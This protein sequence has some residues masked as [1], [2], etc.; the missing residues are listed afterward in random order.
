MEISVLLVLVALIQTRTILSSLSRPI[1][2]LP[3]KAFQG[4]LLKQRP[5]VITYYLLA[6][7][8]CSD[9]HSWLE[10]CQEQQSALGRDHVKTFFLEANNILSLQ[11]V[12]DRNNLQLWSKLRWKFQLSLINKFI[13]KLVFHSELLD[14]INLK[15]LFEHAGFVSLDWKYLPVLAPGFLEFQSARSYLESWGCIGWRDVMCGVL[16]CLV[17]TSGQE[18]SVMLLAMYFHWLQRS[19]F[20]LWKF[21]LLFPGRSM[22]ALCAFSVLR[23]EF[24]PGFRFGVLLDWRHILF[25]QE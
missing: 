10:K 20:L 18:F 19:I 9:F 1:L 3:C 2:G 22:V 14:K 11:R 16:G 5:Q 12:F 6:F 7:K 4:W 25:E 23:F 21:H 8:N 15:I 24:H 13:N 17:S